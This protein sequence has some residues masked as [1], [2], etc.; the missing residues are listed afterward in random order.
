RSNGG[1]RELP[2]IVADL[3]GQNGIRVI[4][5]GFIDSVNG[6]VR[7][8]FLSVPDVPLTKAVFN[9]YGGKRGLIE[10]SK[11]LCATK[12][13]VKVRLKGQ[14]G[15]ESNTNPKIGLPCGKRQGKK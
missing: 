7:T 10:N 12:P 8:R 4:Q 1:E 11:N 6:R 2:D 14:N 9:F 3:R 5:V 13:R 15:A